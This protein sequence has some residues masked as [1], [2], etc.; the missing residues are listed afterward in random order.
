VVNL[1]AA[2]VELPA[3]SAVLLVSGPLDEAGR[4]PADTAVW[5]RA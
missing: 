3:H 5:L 1:S 4:L 2:P